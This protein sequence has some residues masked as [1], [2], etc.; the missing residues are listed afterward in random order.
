MNQDFDVIIVGLGPVGS[1]TALLLEESGLKV[2]AIDKEK[3]IYSLPRAVTISDEGLRIAQAAN[4]EDIYLKNSTK[5]GGAAFVNKNLEVIG[6]VL[7]IEGVI[8]SN[9][10]APSRMFHQPLTDQAMRDKLRRTKV[11]ILLEHELIDLKNE[12]THVN[13]CI[14]DL[15]NKKDFQFSSKYLIGSDG[16]A[17]SVRSLLEISQEDL[18][19]NQDWVVVDV[20]LKGKN[21]LDNKALQ[22]C[23]PERLCTY[24]PSHLPFRRWEFMIN[25]SDNKNDF[26]DDEKIQNLIKRWLQPDQYQIVR[27]AVYQFHSV[28]AEKLNK[29][30][31]FLIGD[32][33]HQAPPFMGEGMMSGYRDAMNVYWK[34]ALTIQ[35][36]LDHKLLNTY[37]KER[38]PHAKFV[39]ENSA[40]IGELMEAYAKTDDPS[41]VP[42]VLVAK[43]YG[44]FVLPGLDEG[45]FYGG[46]ADESMNSGHLFPQPLIYKNNEVFKRED[47]I[48]GNSF[49]LISKD[50]ISI[51]KQD[52]KFLQDI[53]CTFVILDEHYISQ[54]HW[55]KKV[56]DLGE[57]F[58]IRPD[59]YIFGCSSNKVSLEQ[60][61]DDLRKRI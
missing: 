55:V 54:N 57:V 16:G 3:E 39:V 21:Q 28:I 42:D 59:K 32:A 31:S 37:Q 18:N 19:Y 8:T 7:D 4:I 25:E 49:T 15:K 2:L 1:L 61:I 6:G 44:S 45:L 22:I 10:W 53:G 43:G 20:K 46:K 40:G 13:V 34:I 47:E 24:I 36:N 5:L 35:N 23:D 41:K 17:S 60:L 33:A 56:L 38:K 11:T 29:G 52:K 58:L 50:K 48:L 9:G 27:K 12:E 14:K 26:L 51:G 30:R